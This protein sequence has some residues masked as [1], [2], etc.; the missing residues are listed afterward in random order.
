MGEKSDESDLRVR[1]RPG[2]KAQLDKLVE[3]KKTTQ[4]AAVNE[5]VAWFVQQDDFLQSVILGQIRPENWSKVA[6]LI[7]ESLQSKRGP[8]SRR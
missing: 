1:L 3:L 6:D 8:S 5:L 2:L 4:Q 7:H